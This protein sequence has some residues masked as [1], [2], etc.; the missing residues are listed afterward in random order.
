MSDAPALIGAFSASLLPI[1]SGTLAVLRYRDLKR[2]AS[3]EAR[4]AARS[5]TIARLRRDLRQKESELEACQRD[6]DR[7][8]EGL[9][10]WNNRLGEIWIRE[11]KTPPP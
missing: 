3:I 7:A 11:F 10:E 2:K 6:R 4:R 1:V 8:E 5:R 9:A